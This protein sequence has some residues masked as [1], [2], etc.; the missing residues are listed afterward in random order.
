MFSTDFIFRQQENLVD[1]QKCQAGFRPLCNKILLPVWHLSSNTE[2]NLK[3]DW[4]SYTIESLTMY[5][6]KWIE[7]SYNI[8]EK[9]I[10]IYIEL[11][12]ENLNR[13]F[14]KKNHFIF[15]N[16]Y[17]YRFST[18]DYIFLIRKSWPNLDGKNQS[19]CLHSIP[20][21]HKSMLA[22]PNKWH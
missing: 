12:N 11:N 4:A 9:N 16:G 1:N 7:S 21:F 13:L 18:K 20:D 22:C 14:T 6:L 10:L 3:K 19:F 2:L 5:P 17:F 15:T 8:S